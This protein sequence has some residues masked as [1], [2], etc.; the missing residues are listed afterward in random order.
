MEQR[1]VTVHCSGRNLAICKDNMIV[2]TK[3]VTKCLSL[4]VFVLVG[5]GLCVSGCLVAPGSSQDTDGDGIADAVELESLL[6]DGDSDGT[7]NADELVALLLGMLVDTDGDDVPDSIDNA[8]AVANADQADADSD[9]VGD[10][11]D[12]CPN[13]ANAD[14]ADADGDTCDNCPNNANADQ[15]DAD[16][17]GTADV[18]EVVDLAVG[19]RDSDTVLLYLNVLAGNSAQSPEVSLNKAGSGIDQ[20]RSIV[21]ADN[22][23]YVG[24]VRSDTVSIFRNYQSL[25]NN[26]ATTVTLTNAGAAGID[27]PKQLIVADDRLFV[28]DADDDQVLIFNNASSITTEVAPNV[29]LTK[30]GS[31]LDEPS[32]IAVWGS[33]L[34]VSNSASHSVGVFKNIS[35]LASGDAPDVVLNAASS[36]LN[37]PHK[38]FVFDNVLYVF[39]SFNTIDTLLVFSPAD[40][41]TSFQVPDAIIG[42]NSGLEAP[43]AAVVANDNLYVGNRRSN[44]SIFGPG[45]VAFSNADGLNSGQSPFLVLDD[46]SLLVGVNALAFINNHLFVAVTDP[47]FFEFGGVAIFKAPSSLQQ[48]DVPDIFL[49]NPTRHDQASTI[50]IK[51]R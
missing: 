8:P 44:S 51:E 32:A 22:D 26:Q 35:T 17:D 15:T 16:G 20:P 24:N 19:N 33:T 34:F 11:I 18:D 2:K 12:N 27:K 37:E 6:Q 36:K 14:Q 47:F 3:K 28:L 43:L 41:L 7:N 25:S 50:A 9:G 48:G 29:V 40:A 45:L 13:K 1:K 46:A 42:Y 31:S 49:G 38:L 5:L 30:A 23:M 4:I 21:L 10:V 39:N